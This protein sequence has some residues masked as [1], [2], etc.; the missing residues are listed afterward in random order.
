[1]EIPS[2][3]L[4]F[5][6]P[7]GSGGL[8]F[9]EPEIFD[10]V[11]DRDQ[12]FL[13]RVFGEGSTG[14]P[15]AR[16]MAGL[17]N[18][19]GNVAGFFER[20]VEW[21][22]EQGV[23]RG[24]EGYL[25]MTGV[26][27]YQLRAAQMI[28]EEGVEADAV[29]SFF[30]ERMASYAVRHDTGPTG[31]LAQS[32]EHWWQWFDPR[33]AYQSFGEGAPTTIGY[34]GAALLSRGGT[35]LGSAAS[36]GSAGARIAA[37]GRAA[38][39]FARSTPGL[40]MAAGAAEGSL[41]EMDAYELETGQAID[42]AVRLLGSA[43][44][45]VGSAV[46][47]G[48]GIDE[49]LLVGRA[50]GIRGKILQGL[51]AA[52]A[53]GTTE[54]LQE[55]LLIAQEAAYR[56]TGNRFNLPS[57]LADRML[58]SFYGGVVVG[59]GIGG[60]IAALSSSARPPDPQLQ[61]LG[62]R[63][64]GSEIL[65]EFR[66]DLQGHARYGDR[67]SLVEAQDLGLELPAFRRELFKEQ[68]VQSSDIAL[69]DAELFTQFFIDGRARQVGLSPEEYLQRSGLS[70]TNAPPEGTALY[71]FAGVA[72]NMDQQTR[73]DYESAIQ[74]YGLGVDPEVIRQQTGW[75]TGEDG[76]W[77][78]EL[79]VSRIKVR[80]RQAIT[81]PG[82]GPLAELLGYDSPILRAYPQLASLKVSRIESPDPNRAGFSTGHIGIAVQ[83]GA[84][85]ESENQ[86]LGLLVHE[87]Q[88]AIQE[89]EGF[90]TGGSQRT[91]LTE[92]EQGLIGTLR[93]RAEIAFGDMRA[94]Q[95]SAA[96]AADLVAQEDTPA[97][98]LRLAEASAAERTS[99]QEYQQIKA[100]LDELS[101]KAWERY[102]DLAG[103]RE[104]RNAT[105]RMRLTERLR[106][107][108][109]PNETA[110]PLVGPKVI[111]QFKPGPAASR[112]RVE[113]GPVWTSRMFDELEVG[114]RLPRQATGTEM[115]EKI[116]ALAESGRFK[117]EEFEWSGLQ[118]LLNTNEVVTREQVLE[119]VQNG[120]VQIEEL[121]L[122]GRPGAEPRGID[123]HRVRE[124]YAADR[125]TSLMGTQVFTEAE[126]RQ[127]AYSQAGAFIEE[128]R[129]G[130]AGRLRNMTQE[131]LAAF[132]LPENAVQ[133]VQ[134]AAPKEPIY[135]QYTLP[136]GQNYRELLFKL[137]IREQELGVNVPASNYI[138]PHWQEPNVLAHARLTDRIDSE[139]RRVLFVE[140]IQSDWLQSGRTR[141]FVD[142]PLGDAVRA[143]FIETPEHPNRAG[144][145]R[146][147]DANDAI[148]SELTAD[149][150]ETEGAAIEYANFRE[151]V[152][153]RVPDAP[154]KKTWPQLVLKRLLRMAAEGGY[155][156]IALTDGQ[157]I[158]ESVGGVEEG[159]SY[160]YD[161]FLPSQLKKLSREAVREIILTRA[162]EFAPYI[163][164]NDA[165][166]YTVYRPA[167]GSARRIG[168]IYETKQEAEERIQLELA[169]DPI[170]RSINTSFKAVPISTDLYNRVIQGQPLF[171]AGLAG[172][173]GAFSI[174]EDGRKI[175]SLM[176]GANVSTL[177]HEFGHHLRQEL[178]GQELADAEQIFGVKD[179]NWSITNEEH[180]ARALENFVR[181]GKTK[182]K[183]LR[184]PFQRM[185]ERMAEV[186]LSIRGSAIDVQM[187]PDT[188]K[189]FD[190]LIS[191]ELPTDGNVE[192]SARWWQ[193]ALEFFSVRAQWAR[194]EAPRTGEAIIRL[195]SRREAKQFEALDVYKEM[196]QLLGS[197]GRILDAVLAYESKEELARIEQSGDTQ[198]QQAARIFG[199]YMEDSLAEYKR[200]GGL[201]V[202]FVEAMRG[203][204]F[205]KIQRIVPRNLP[206][207]VLDSILEGTLTDTEAQAA[208]ITDTKLLAMSEL[209]QQLNR[210][211]DVNFVH[212][213]LTWFESYVDASPE[214]SR[215]VL[216]VL[217]QKERKSI[218]IGDLIA[219]GVISR[220]EIEA[221]DIFASY[222]QRKGRDLALLELRN[223]AEEEGV[224]RRSTPGQ[225]V[226]GLWFQTRHPLFQGYDVNGPMNAWLREMTQADGGFGM[227]RRFMNSA[228]VLAFYNPAILNSYNVIQLSMAGAQ[229]IRALPAAMR[230]GFNDWLNRTP[231]FWD[232]LDQGIS[233]QPFALP[234]SEFR[235]SFTR[236]DEFGVGR[237][238]ALGMTKRLLVGGLMGATAGSTVAPGIGTVAGGLAGVGIA[239]ARPG[240]LT[241][242]T[243]SGLSRAVRGDLNKETFKDLAAWGA[244]PLKQL[245]ELSWDM[246]WSFDLMSR[247]M[248]NRLYLTEGLTSEESARQAALVFGD[249][250][251][252]PTST[253]KRLNTVFFT[254]TYKIA[255][256]QL[257]TDSIRSVGNI[258]EG[259]A[260]ISHRQSAAVVMNTAAILFGYD[261]MMMA[262]GWERDEWGRRYFKDVQVEYD[263]ALNQGSPKELVTVFGGPHD[264]F[265]KYYLRTK[266]AMGPAV[267][268]TLTQLWNANRWELHPV[269]RV[270]E[271]MFIRNEDQNGN[272]IFSMLDHPSEKAVKAAWF[273]TRSIVGMLSVLGGEEGLDPQGTRL[274][275]Q[276]AAKTTPGFARRFSEQWGQLV[277]IMTGAV[278][279][280]Y[281]RD[282]SVIRTTR[283]MQRI[284]RELMNDIRPSVEDIQR[285]MTA[286][287]LEEIVNSERVAGRVEEAMRR[288]DIL[289]QRLEQELYDANLRDAAYQEEAEFESVLEFD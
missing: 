253:R 256:A 281:A 81:Q 6:P 102:Q 128:L 177:V 85:F 87:L 100:Q 192:K 285:G 45:G 23:S 272:P 194:A 139:G 53:E 169:D 94:A 143:E 236:V 167:G 208:G 109:P 280:Q 288:L 141:G 27:D 22:A 240:Q 29:S 212:L 249:Y 273:A 39:Q 44:I 269:L 61:Y 203:R 168:G 119:F 226:D 16:G 88:H 232:A 227:L 146:L 173:Q 31:V 104:A 144:F 237:Q 151:P 108:I 101:A 121:L 74:A 188:K 287:E 103:E 93:A 202:G 213:P 127:S 47:E 11:T 155:D 78:Y 96:R 134:E 92:Q 118:D 49:L 222:G 164:G 90:A 7:S 183:R 120:G 219:E 63:Q 218:S 233:S 186:Y 276:E 75:F 283:Q 193:P 69:G 148:H 37:T 136:G 261:L 211:D 97:A 65:P 130:D 24:I 172:P 154:F 25:R 82:E 241:A 216:Q 32:P 51:I 245:Y 260:N 171:Q 62:A 112:E 145:W 229:N 132:G 28:R 157:T 123:W 162:S 228:K 135:S 116:E 56:E 266:N 282:P 196:F 255:M 34:L 259:S 270:M 161:T 3:S 99:N 166:G 114:G 13:D 160:F 26:P 220:E 163:E 275:A 15:W 176:E 46:L 224:I 33:R 210:L 195:H 278:T 185:K 257:F 159:Q 30:Q 279:F 42:P 267:P 246:A 124:A 122:T 5:D 153:M 265:Y 110:D 248:L 43:A 182:H 80:D 204:L 262:L 60:G 242:R 57:D 247:L 138:G 115:L 14:S 209:I 200:L 48:F 64:V 12:G 221:K 158:Q 243:V 215:R 289:K 274:F 18:E 190:D 180:F 52:G 152:D 181:T 41:R 250:A 231:E 251:N 147:F 268:N 286:E 59:T 105:A 10:P 223:A 235:R 86:F 201:Q 73:S 67:V 1:M 225:Q 214:G 191:S 150:A 17:Y 252:V 77:R 239:L 36:A 174:A 70:V 79:D 238:R 230:D 234:Y 35:A 95:E 271:D 4:I 76:K 21:I 106:Q 258:L 83:R 54:A 178:Q 2:D 117:R 8:V 66:V 55:S 156:Y 38:F 199:R 72:S 126:A 170:A 98:Q 20:Q 149:L 263:E 165:D 198:M 175:I 179:A 125:I 68:I 58:S 113:P 107:Q 84:T 187:T 254:P 206:P 277:Q 142:Q 111:L 19:L 140:E 9:D 184:T 189:F 131:Q 244:E 91:V 197:P 50:T 40:L 217:A 264:L 205:E 71:Q 284:Q 207:Q 129:R 89:I 137:P 133:L